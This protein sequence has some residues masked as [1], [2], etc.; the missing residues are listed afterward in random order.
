MCVYIW[1]NRLQIVPSLFGLL[2]IT[3][4]GIFDIHPVL[5]HC[6]T[7]RKQCSF[8]RKFITLNNTL[9]VQ[10]QYHELK[11]E[12]EKGWTLFEIW[13]NAHPE[14]KQVDIVQDQTRQFLTLCST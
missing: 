2:I 3:G 5:T 9:Q 6:F 4:F 11:Y 12:T 1:R 8:L 10:E 7:N 13:Q 14:I